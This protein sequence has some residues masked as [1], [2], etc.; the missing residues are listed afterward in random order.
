MIKEYSRVTTIVKKCGYPVGTH[1]VVVSVYA[2]GK[3]CEVELWDSDDYPIDV[4]TYRFDELS[5]RV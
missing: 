2:S 3:A 4:I 1:G 5:E